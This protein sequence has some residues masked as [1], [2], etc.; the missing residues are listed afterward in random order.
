MKK[1]HS[2]TPEL[3]LIFAGFLTVAIAGRVSGNTN[4]ALA[5]GLVSL[6]TGILGI[7]HRLAFFALPNRKV[8]AIIGAITTLVGVVILHIE[9]DGILTPFVLYSGLA[10]L[11]SLFLHREPPT[12]QREEW[13]S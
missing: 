6:V 11:S 4:S 13:V 1:L 10:I 5:I 8:H 12:K 9:P 7:I 2:F 3:I